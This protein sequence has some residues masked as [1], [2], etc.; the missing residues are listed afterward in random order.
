MIDYTEVRRNV[1]NALTNQLD[2][3]PAVVIVHENTARD[4]V[5]VEHVRLEDDGIGSE[6]LEMGGSAKLVQGL[7]HFHIFT[8]LGI[9]TERARTIASKIEELL[10]SVSDGITYTDTT[11]QSIGEI[12]E[13]QLYKHLLTASYLYVYGQQE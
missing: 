10:P 4:I 9:G 13:L 5:G 6:N 1:E 8:K 11:L 2:V 12:E 3:T 7:L